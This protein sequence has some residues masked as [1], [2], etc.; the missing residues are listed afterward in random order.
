MPWLEVKD[1]EQLPAMAAHRFV[2]LRG[3]LLPDEELTVFV[4]THWPEQKKHRNGTPLEMICTE[5]KFSR[6]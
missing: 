2:R 1:R 5:F 3:G 4:Y 6:P